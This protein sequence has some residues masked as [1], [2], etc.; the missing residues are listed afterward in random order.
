MNFQSPSPKKTIWLCELN[1]YLQSWP[2]DARS[3]KC[4]IV[5]IFRVV[6]CTSACMCPVNRLHLKKRSKLRFAQSA[7]AYVSRNCDVS[8]CA[9]HGCCLLS[10]KLWKLGPTPRNFE[11]NV[12]PL[13]T[14]DDLWNLLYN[15]VY[16]G[17]KHINSPKCFGTPLNFIKHFKS[18][19]YRFS[20]LLRCCCHSKA[21]TFEDIPWTYR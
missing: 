4:L 8:S 3:N 17:N 10:L 11:M 14:T 18:R 6:W 16:E 21:A 2:N 15:K 9:L 20:A 7:D 19:G 5:V 13:G 12:S 1:G